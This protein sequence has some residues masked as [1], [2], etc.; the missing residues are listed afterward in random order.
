MIRSMANG[1]APGGS[2][3]SYAE[4]K[5]MSEKVLD[6]VSDMCNISLRRPGLH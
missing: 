6:D 5:C 4:L 1:S 2:G 3:L